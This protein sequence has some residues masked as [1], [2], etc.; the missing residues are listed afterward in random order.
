M[1]L[2]DV[3]KAADVIKAYVEDFD[4]M[5]LILNLIEPESP[6]HAELLSHLLMM[7]PDLKVIYFPS[8]F[9]WLMSPGLKLLQKI[10]RPEY[11]P[12]DLYSIFA[13]EKYN[14]DLIN[15]IFVK[16]KTS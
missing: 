14:N 6:T 3:H 16:I 12:I 7:R 15:K 5:P 11:K 10:L 1:G 13:P 9:L 2:C 8:I 4:D